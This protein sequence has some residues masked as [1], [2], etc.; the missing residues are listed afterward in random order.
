[1]KLHLI[2]KTF[3]LFSTLAQED[4]VENRLK[5]SLMSLLN[6]ST[7]RSCY[8]LNVDNDKEVRL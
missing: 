5:D 1:M 7:L 3:N 2:V 6:K 4:K 8:F